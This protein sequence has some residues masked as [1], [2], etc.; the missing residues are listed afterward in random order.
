[1]S[2][3][4]VPSLPRISVLM[5]C[6]NGRRFIAEA[7]AS[8]RRQSYPDLEHIVLDACST[9]GTLQLLRSF[10]DVRVISE[11]DDSAHEAMNKGLMLASGEIIGF[12]AVDDLYPDGTLADV[13]ALFAARPDV[14]VVVGHA[15][16]FDDAEPERSPRVAYTH[17]RGLWLPELMF[18]V[19]GFCGV[20][21]RRRVFA[22]LGGFD[23]SFDFTAD[24]D[25]LVRVALAG[26]TSARLDRPTIL[27]R[28]HPGSRTVNPERVNRLEISREHVRMSLVRARALAPAT[29][30]RRELLAW[31][32]FAGARLAA[33]CAARREFAESARMLIGLCRDNPLWPLRLVRALALRR[34][35][36][37][38][39]PPR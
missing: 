4:T 20:F 22:R 9:D 33:L 27:Y 6:R 31:H 21:F 5:P 23:E 39:E 37:E 10:P 19:S 3:P 38:L 32:A 17:P 30:A 11:A 26:L 24:L 29:S 18:G 7:I 36:R 8:V 2:D 12:L 28:M 15:V 34:S 14:D 16:V 35:V 1:L 13:G 25:L